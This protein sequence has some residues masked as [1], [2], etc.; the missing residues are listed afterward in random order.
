MRLVR[1]PRK[2]ESDN[3]IAINA[4]SGKI[5]RS[6]NRNNLCFAVT[7]VAANRWSPTRAGRIS[8]RG[9]P[10]STIYRDTRPGY[11]DRGSGFTRSST[12][13]Y[14]KADRSVRTMKFD[15]V[16]EYVF[17]GGDVTDRWIGSRHTEYIA[18]F[19]EKKAVIFARSEA[20]PRQR[21]MNPAPEG[22]PSGS[23]GLSRLAMSVT[24]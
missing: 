23:V 5:S 12:D 1:I 20:E 24:T 8:L 19:A 13:G 22:S 7:M 4:S 11:S 10:G 21:A 16:F 3:A 2:K 14:A 18:E 6:T 17:V 15:T 9:P